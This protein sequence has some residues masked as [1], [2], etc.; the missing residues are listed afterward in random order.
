MTN[1]EAVETII[2]FCDFII[3]SD[4]YGYRIQGEL[5]EA[6][7]MAVRALSEQKEQKKGYWVQNPITRKHFCSECGNGSFNKY[8][9]YGA[10]YCPICGAKMDGDENE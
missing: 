7:S 1:K 5:V 9:A 8:F 4:E 2:H 10:R 6:H 3:P